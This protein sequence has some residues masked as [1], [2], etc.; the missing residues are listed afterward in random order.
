[1]EE[2]LE[3]NNL[4]LVPVNYHLTVPSYRLHAAVVVGIILPHTAHAQL[5]NPNQ[6][7]TLRNYPLPQSNIH[8]YENKDIDNFCWKTRRF[9]YISS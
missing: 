2:N 1:M 6:R 5:W 7:V 4:F 9:S 3:G 8:S